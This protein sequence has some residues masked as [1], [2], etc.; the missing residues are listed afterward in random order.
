VD[1][2]EGIQRGENNMNPAQYQKAA[3]RT[4]IDAPGFDISNTEQMIIWTALGLAGETGEVVELAKKGIFHQHG[5]DKER[6]KK[7]LG[8]C[9][10]YIAGLCTKLGLSLEDVMQDN[11]QKLMVRYPDGYSSEDSV[12]RMDVK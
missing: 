2:R 5:I 10:W 4:L 12:A 9:L 8:D 1:G 3:A 11:I 7:E 6:F